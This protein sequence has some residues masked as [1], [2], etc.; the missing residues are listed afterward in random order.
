[1]NTLLLRFSERLFGE[2]SQLTIQENYRCNLFIYSLIL[3]GENHRK[4]LLSISFIK[5]DMTGQIRV[6]HLNPIDLMHISFIK[7]L[8]MLKLSHLLGSNDEVVD[9]TKIT[10][11]ETVEPSGYEKLQHSVQTY[12]PEDKCM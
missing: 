2:F 12:S 1:M 11:T 5:K 6:T 8:S 9:T 3:L 7:V 10:N 4:A